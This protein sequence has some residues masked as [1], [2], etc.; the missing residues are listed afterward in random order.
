MWIHPIFCS[1]VGR[2]D[3]KSY[4]LWIAYS[5]FVPKSVSR[6]SKVGNYLSEHIY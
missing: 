5:C 1:K 2:G 4:N 3:A 6:Q